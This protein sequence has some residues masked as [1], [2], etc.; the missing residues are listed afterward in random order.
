VTFKLNQNHPV[1]NR[2]SVAA[3][4]EQQSREPSREIAALMRACT[5]ADDGNEP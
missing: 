1:A 2:L 3:E 5:P 4:L